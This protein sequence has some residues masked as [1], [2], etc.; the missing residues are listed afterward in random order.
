[1]AKAAQEAGMAQVSGA[2]KVAAMTGVMENS[3]T[4]EPATAWRIEVTVTTRVSWLAQTTET[5]EA[6]GMT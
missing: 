5:V 6:A 2:T 4:A 1:M 3:A